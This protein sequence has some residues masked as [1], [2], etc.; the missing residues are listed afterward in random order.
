MFSINNEETYSSNS[1]GE[2]TEKIKCSIFEKLFASKCSLKEHIAIVHDGKKPFKC[3]V[4]NTSCATQS[5]LKK[6]FRTAHE[7]NNWNKHRTWKNI[8]SWWKKFVIFLIVIK[9]SKD[10]QWYDAK[11]KKL[12]YTKLFFLA[13]IHENIKPLIKK[14]LPL[15]DYWKCMLMP[16]IIVYV[17]FFL[18]F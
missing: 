7:E 12:R 1:W 5:K 14:S 13:A 10:Y 2:K 17:I 6:H 3:D 11:A 9:S 18:F 8:C 15:N 4:C 16:F